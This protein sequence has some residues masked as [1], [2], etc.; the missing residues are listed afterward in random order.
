MENSGA[1]TQEVPEGGHRL[2]MPG[3]NGADPRV[4]AVARAVERY[5]ESLRFGQHQITGDWV[6]CIGETGGPV[7]GFGPDLPNPDDV[8]RKL[9]A[10]DVKRR[11]RQILDGLARESEARKA[12]ARLAMDDATMEVVEHMEHGFRQEGKHPTPRIFVP[13]T[14]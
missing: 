4:R 3:V 14:W 5:D 10:V 11:G 8:E 12:A 13:R 2:W 7:F 9:A 6:V 1:F